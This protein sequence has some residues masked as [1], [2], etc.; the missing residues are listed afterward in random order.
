VI[1]LDRFAGE[2]LDELRGEIL[3][4]SAN[5]KPAIE[6][7][8]ATADALSSRRGADALEELYLLEHIAGVAREQQQWELAQ[9]AA[10]LMLS[11]DP[12]Y[13][14]AHYAAALVARHNGQTPKFQQESALARKLWA[15]ADPGLPELSQ[16]GAQ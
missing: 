16:H 4:R 11:F 8:R 5:K 6:L 1:T 7:L 10:T 13:F 9:Y 12:S 2:E 3:L 14:G 15:R